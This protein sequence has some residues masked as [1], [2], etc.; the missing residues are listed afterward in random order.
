M[1]DDT[2]DWDLRR[3]ESTLRRIKS[4]RDALS[5]KMAVLKKQIMYR[6]QKQRGLV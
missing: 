1:S 3:L 5:G 4:E 6:K 2:L